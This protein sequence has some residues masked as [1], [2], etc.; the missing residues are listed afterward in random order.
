[1]KRGLRVR[2]VWFV[3]AAV[4]FTAGFS[5]RQSGC[6]PSEENADEERWEASRQAYRDALSPYFRAILSNDS[7]SLDRIPKKTVNPY[8]ARRKT[9]YLRRL[10][11]DFFK[12]T[13]G[14]ALVGVEP[15]LAMAALEPDELPG[16]ALNNPAELNVWHNTGHD[17]GAR[18]SIE[19]DNGRILANM[20]MPEISHYQDILRRDKIKMYYAEPTTPE[21]TIKMV[22]WSLESSSTPPSAFLEMRVK[23]AGYKSDKWAGINAGKLKTFFEYFRLYKM[24]LSADYYQWIHNALPESMPEP[25][26]G[27][28]LY[29][30]KSAREV[31]GARLLG[32]GYGPLSAAIEPYDPQGELNNPARFDVWHNS[33]DDVRVAIVISDDKKNI[34]A[35]FEMPHMSGFPGT[36]RREEIEISFNKP[37]SRAGGIKLYAVFPGVGRQYLWQ[38]PVT[39]AGYK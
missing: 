22:A 29:F 26:T 16:G 37:A 8:P 12:R 32:W 27:K 36:L 33:G 1:M 14:R 30:R 5:V 35:D 2:I 38:I 4:F 28:P 25:K 13:K 3:A 20:K 15:W 24:A 19:D 10:A 31:S 18:I 17:S 34:L 7:S 6:A 21:G 11:A 9:L 39:F 23:F